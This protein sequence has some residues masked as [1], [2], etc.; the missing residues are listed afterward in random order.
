[1]T[2]G[3]VE[4]G[5]RA[6]DV[7]RQIGRDLARAGIEKVILI[8]NSVTSYIEHGLKEADYKGEVMRFDDMPAALAALP[9]L[10]AEGDVILMQNDWPDQYA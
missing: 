1:M 5:D 9:H 10:A 4:M 6:E 8:K 2:P 3:L 7:H